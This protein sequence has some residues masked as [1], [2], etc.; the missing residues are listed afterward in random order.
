MFDFKRLEFEKAFDFRTFWKNRVWILKLFELRMLFQPVPLHSFH[1]QQQN[2]TDLVWRS[3]AMIFVPAVRV[4][5]STLWCLHSCNRVNEPYK[6]LSCHQLNVCLLLHWG[7]W[8]I[9]KSWQHPFL[10]CLVAFKTFFVFVGGR[11]QRKVLWSGRYTMEIT[12]WRRL[13]GGWRFR[14]VN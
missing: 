1:L 8:S 2:S 4:C 3:K 9:V 13:L 11:H 6:L 10:F 7:R 14:T 5:N 12:L